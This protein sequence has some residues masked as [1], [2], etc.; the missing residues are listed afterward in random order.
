MTK[1]R[2]T[3]ALSILMLI[4]VIITLIF[5]NY[6]SMK[7]KESHA[8]E[9]SFEKLTEANY[10]KIDKISTINYTLVATDNNKYGV[11]D[12]S[13]IIIVPFEYDEIVSKKE[14]DKLFLVKKK[15]FYG[16]VDIYNEIIVPV[17][18]NNEDILFIY[19]GYIG[20]RKNN[21]CGLL[22]S[23]G[24][25]IIDYIYDDMNSLK[26]KL[27]PV[28]KDGKWGYVDLDNN[29][30]IEFQYE[31]ALAFSTS[32]APVQQNDKWGYINEK[33]KVITEF[34]FDE[35]L[36]FFE[37]YANVRLNEKWGYIYKNGML[38][39]PT[40]YDQKRDNGMIY[41]NEKAL[42][43]FEGQKCGYIGTS[44]AEITSLE[45]NECGHFHNGMATVKING[46]V[47]V[48]N[49]SGSYVIPLNYTNITL[50]SKNLLKIQKG[51]LCGIVNIKN[52]EVLPYEYT[53]DGI[54]IDNNDLI[55]ISLGDNGQKILN[56]Y[57]QEI[58]RIEYQ[59]LKYLGENLYM[60]SNDNIKFGLLKI[61]YE[62]KK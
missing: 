39:I 10:N 62:E 43:V 3:Y 58:G 47:G 55:R 44:G 17:E 50:G 40:N 18:Y 30:I 46:K 37:N 41:F 19:G 7:Q 61:N 16:I 51:D 4:G 12:S 20:L 34:K 60:Y 53:C 52:K 38:V 9:F 54:E 25:Q 2:I 13:G 35:A 27:L 36:P 49:S 5:I 26:E 15:D 1:K 32:L 48:I 29:L 42:L 8:F 45:F 59:T 33:N 31:N 23:S 57:K 6:D 24:K 14:Y 22:D 28:K 21:L 56:K 11:L